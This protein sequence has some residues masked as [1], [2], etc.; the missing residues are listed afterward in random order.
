VQPIF[1]AGLADVV[2]VDA[3]LGDGLRL[4]PTPGHTPGHTSL[5]IESAGARAVVTGDLIHHP[6]Q[7][8]EPAWKEIGDVDEALATTT[9]RAFLDEVAGTDTL[10]VGTHFPTRPAGHVVA[11]GEAYRFL[12]A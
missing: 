2:A 4:A 5:W 12:P 8:A 10:V 6:V 3:D 7:C 11:A 9:R 1:D